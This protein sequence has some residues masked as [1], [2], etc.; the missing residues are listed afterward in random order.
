M[1]T[2]LNDNNTNRVRESPLLREVAQRAGRV[3]IFAED[4]ALHSSLVTVKTV[5]YNS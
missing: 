3:A 5:P 4:P 1:G 2:A